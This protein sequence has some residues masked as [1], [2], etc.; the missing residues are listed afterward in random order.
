[1][2]S[3]QAG[4][5]PSVT[6]NLFSPNFR[7][8]TTSPSS[9]VDLSKFVRIIMQLYYQKINKKDNNSYLFASL[10]IAK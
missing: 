8:P 4:S 5:D 7:K 10:S 3:G 9:L 6:N 1:M 2:L